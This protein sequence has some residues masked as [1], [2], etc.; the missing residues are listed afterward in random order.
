MDRMKLL[1]LAFGG[2][3]IAACGGSDAAET[4][5]VSGAATPTSAATLTAASSPSPAATAPASATAQPSST[6]VTSPT[7]EPTKPVP[8]AANTQ[9]A[10]PATPA[11]V[12][13]TAT[14]VPQ[15][16][17]ASV[18][19]SAE[20]IVFSPATVTIRAGGKVTW[21]WANKTY[22]NVSG[23]GFASEVS[24]TGPFSTAFANPG[25]YAYACEIHPDTMR[26]TVIVQ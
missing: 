17:P 7:T 16:A 25:T 21:V 5:T 6:P 23:P 26:G 20:A 10:Q 12:Q 15:G 14:P 1:V 22:H 2:L 24:N 13:P 8:T 11:P 9:A 18:T 19:V 3:F 4:S